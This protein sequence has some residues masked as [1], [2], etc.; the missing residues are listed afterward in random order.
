MEIQIKI[1]GFL[2]IILTLMHVCFPKYFNWEEELRRLSL[3]NR[4]MMV[5]HTFFIALVLLMMGLLCI[6]SADE[7]VQT[8]LGK[9]VSLGFGIFW[10]VRSFIQ[11]FGYSSRLWRGKRFETF[12]HIL[13]SLIWLYFSVVFFANYLKGS[14]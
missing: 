4:Q 1:A 7:L 2:M 12:I 9:T 6:T 3:I 14:S 11:F 5:V 10:T 8:R 13:F